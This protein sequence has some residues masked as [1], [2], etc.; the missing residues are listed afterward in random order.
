MRL[1]LDQNLSPR[2]IDRLADCYPG[3]A[4]VATLGL[5]RATDL[6][7]WQHARTHGFALVTKDA[8][9]GEIGLLRGFPPLVIWIRFGNCSTDHIEAAL[10]SVKDSVGPL[11]ATPSLGLLVLS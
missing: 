3:S 6:E 10:R 4:H 5:G 2:L 11:A 9:F 7:V 8:D 1:L